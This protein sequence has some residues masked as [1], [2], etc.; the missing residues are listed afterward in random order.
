MTIRKL[1]AVLAMLAV[2][3]ALAPGQANAGTIY[4]LNQP[5]SGVSAYA[6][7]YG[8][9]DVTRIDATHATVVLTALS[10]APNYF[11]FG[12]GGTLGLNTNGAVTVLGGNAGITASNPGGS[13]LLDPSG[14]YSVAGAGNEDGFG[15]FNF[16]ISLNN[17][18][19]SAKRAVSSLS[20]ELVKSSGSW[21]SDSDV[22]TPN[23][24]G[25]SAAGH[26]FVYNST[27]TAGPDGGNV[28]PTGFAA[29]G[30]VTVP[31]PASLV[32]LGIGGFG[33]LGV[34]LRKRRLKAKAV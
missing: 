22:L 9:V 34:A 28:V 27:Y 10:N 13:F 12:D 16:R 24:S 30:P 20:F 32:L 25:Y 8:T 18:E 14:K 17:G 21:S 23:G 15:N 4:T 26:V 29:D 3:V 6:G 7:P 19:N 2:L 11:L 33:V 31:E 1:F 5:N